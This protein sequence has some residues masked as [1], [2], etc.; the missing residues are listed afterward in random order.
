VGSPETLAHA[1][2]FKLPAPGPVT[3]QNNNGP[4]PAT[5]EETP[6]RIDARLY[7]QILERVYFSIAT[8]IY[9]Q[10][11]ED[12][13]RKIE[14]LPTTYFRA[15]ALFHEAE[16]YARSTTLDAYDEALELYGQAIEAFD[17]SLKPWPK[18]RLRRA[19][20]SLALVIHDI[21]QALVKGLVHSFPR[22]GKNRVNVRSRRDR[23]CEHAALSPVS[24]RDFAS[25][26]QS[27]LR[28]A[29]GRGARGGTVESG[30]AAGGFA[31]PETG[32]SLTG[33]VTLAFACSS[34]GSNHNRERVAGRISP[35]RSGAHGKRCQVSLC[36]WRGKRRRERQDS[37]LSA[38]SRTRSEVRRG[39]IFT[40]R[41][42]EM[43]WRTRA[44][45]ERQ[46]SRAGFQGIPAV[47]TTNPGVVGA[48]SNLGY[49]R[50][51]LGDAELARDAFE[52]GREYKEIKHDTYV[53]EL[54]YGLA[55][56]AAE[57]GDFEEAYQLYESGV[58]AYGARRRAQLA[59]QYGRVLS[60]RANQSGDHESL[61]G[62]PAGCRT[63]RGLWADEADHDRGFAAVVE[64][65]KRI[66]SDSSPEGQK[67]ATQALK[68]FASVLK[69]AAN[70]LNSMKMNLLKAWAEKAT[71]SDD[72][73]PALK[74]GSLRSSPK[75]YGS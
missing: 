60:L 73:S 70:R 10:I 22:L 54:D 46:R 4:Q 38:R 59:R 14:L 53:A 58:S 52:G 32:V 50:W 62:L 65:L 12:V 29:A 66:C 7:E 16:D 3:P 75:S 45:L 21:R 63:N 42:M 40:R 67:K 23:V 48:W 39:P 47:T 34:L 44:T 31:A 72:E 37:A 57:Q 71:K 13:K 56:I 8:E 11:Q 18:A 43:L 28:S 26:G 25:T 69:R 74:T 2:K 9:K 61:R 51:L 27:G 55:R 33:Y 68:G 41:P 35:S 17:P 36:V 20:R 64:E 24:G 49:M 30:A 5:L 15:V 1:V 19:F 6:P